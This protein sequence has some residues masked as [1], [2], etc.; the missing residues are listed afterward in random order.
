[1]FS[2][3]WNIQKNGSVDRYECFNERDYVNDLQNYSSFGWTLYKVRIIELDDKTLDLESD[4][5]WYDQ[6]HADKISVLVRRVQ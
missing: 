3:L 5:I 4:K 6:N 2:V 1:M